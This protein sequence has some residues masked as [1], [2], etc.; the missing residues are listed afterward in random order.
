MQSLAIAV[1]AIPFLG[2]V[3]C[4][5]VRDRASKLVAVAATS[6][7]GILAIGL[8]SI[9]PNETRLFGSM[10]WLGV[11]TG[12]FGY[13]FDALAI[14]MLLA[15]TLIGAAITIYSTGYL[16]PGNHEHATK[17]GQ[18]RYYFW[19]MTFV[20]AMVGI[21]I[22]PTLLQLLI[23]WEMTTLCSWALISFYDNKESLKAGMKA[24]RRT[25]GQ[26]PSSPS[27]CC[28]RQRS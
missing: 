22:S 8:A 2:A 23:F 26:S 27:R 21:A 19:L 24:F 5:A 28:S 6:I 20:G 17:S 25:W 1:L 7:T 15:S 16:S 10:P 18:A 14:I 12:L 3:A 11:T 9:M 4:L 13:Q